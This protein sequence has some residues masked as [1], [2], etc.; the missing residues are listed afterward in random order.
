MK[1]FKFR[2]TSGI[3]SAKIQAAGNFVI[4]PV[5]LGII[6]I[7]ST[8]QTKQVQYESPKQPGLHARQ[9]IDL[10][11]EPQIAVIT[12]GDFLI[13]PATVV[14]A[15]P[16]L[17]DLSP[18]A[19]LQE[20]LKESIQTGIGK[21][22]SPTSKNSIML[23]L[24]PEQSL[25]E[26]PAGSPK[27]EAYSL[28]VTPSQ[29]TISASYP[30]GLFYGVQTLLQLAEQG[31]GHIRGLRI[32]DWPD[33][34]FRA[35]H[36][37][38]WYHLDRPWYY[39]YLFKQ[40]AY[41][42]INT[43]VFEFEDKFSYSK[44]PVLSAPNAM[45]EE[46]VGQLIQKAKQYFI[47]IV[48]LVQ[49]LGHVGFIAKHP[50]FSDLRE[51]AMSNWQLC[52]LKEG[53]FPL[54]RDILDDVMRV[55][56]PT[57][58]FHIG[59]DEAREL[60]MGPECNAKWGDKAPVESYKLWLNFVCDY[61][62]KRGKTAIVWDDMF[63]RYFSKADMANLPDN[64][65]YMRWNYSAGTIDEKGRKILDLGYPVWIATAAQTM[66]PVFPDQKLR[67]YNNANLIPN[68]VSLGSK[69]AL[70]T[71]W[72]D[73]GTHPETYWMGFV[74]SAEYSWS[75]RKPETEEFMSKFFNL[76]YGRDQME[77]NK[78]YTTLSE[79]GFIRSES[80]WTREFAALDL[81]PLPDT[82]YRVDS[83]WAGKH[84]KLIAQAKEMRPRYA[85]SVEIIT[86]NLAGD[87]KNKYNLEVLLLCAK[88]MLHFTDL[89]L[90][91]N[92]INDNLMAA[93][94][95]HRKGDD[96][97][98]INRYH[99]IGRIIDDLRY[100]KS[101]LFD[102][103][104]RIWEKSMF[105]KDFRDIPG[106]REKFVHQVDRDF[107]YGNKTMDLSYIFEIEEQ[108]GFFAY[109]QKLYRVAVDILRRR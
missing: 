26:V 96:Q 33:M 88:T 18:V 54:I 43:I 6:F 74:C 49:T 15:D 101:I 24:I 30:A 56:Q 72:E 89:I 67:V 98:A 85:Q 12:G 86:K 8:A 35:I 11:P 107:Y 84:S 58:Y 61:L 102:E 81:P 65:I 36:V 44:H 46:Q 39:E 10:I 95:D 3:D 5:I 75:S 42:K 97:A 103:T 108:I 64:L 34:E 27:K 9:G 92:E 80:S 109:Q 31:Q 70:N 83:T 32:V 13:N 94:A 99:R 60:G 55:V 66:T 37:D 21:T 82:E 1:K 25:K 19:C 45:S 91:I 4:H 41:Y 68:A 63:L 57:K 104:V 87:T 59:G 48:P 51:V 7:L 77:L 76:F 93:D 53:T 79:K 71:A 105:P 29:I 38:L 73:P 78:V 47:E 22:G 23:K 52:P 14:Y 40:L 90:S 28:E 2:T 106:G 100:N 20:G 50:E 17:Q 69:G 62:K 16:K